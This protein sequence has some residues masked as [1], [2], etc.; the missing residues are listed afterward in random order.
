MTRALAV[1]GALLLAACH[2]GE[3]VTAVRIQVTFPSAFDQV[4]FTL[5]LGNAPVAPPALRPPTPSGA[6]SGVQDFVVYLDDDRAGET[7]QCSA[8]PLLQGRSRAS[9]AGQV[10]VQRREVVV[11]PISFPPGSASVD[12]A[13]AQD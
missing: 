4:L 1:A 8:E 12:A 3:P 6:L 11:C 10:T 7:A 5:S 9:G 2:P 13:A